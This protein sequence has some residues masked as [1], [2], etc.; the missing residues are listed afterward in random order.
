MSDD[1]SEELGKNIPLSEMI[2][3]LRSELM[4][5][6]EMGAGKQL[7]F[8]VGEVELEL[9]VKINREK[10]AGGGL[11][12]WVLSGKA[13]AGRSDQTVHTFRLKLNPVKPGEPKSGGAGKE[14][15]A[16]PVRISDR[17]TQMPR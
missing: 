13:E 11:K 1:L 12:F 8:D 10:S 5:A 9:Q 16:G 4:V 17:E 14:R 15:E 3:T 2:Q 6:M 7:Q